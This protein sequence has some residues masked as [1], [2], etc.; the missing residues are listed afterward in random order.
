MINS[1][2]GRTERWLCRMWRVTNKKLQLHIRWVRERAGDV[3][4]SI[5]DELADLGTRVEAQH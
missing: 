4:N 5:A 1:W 3:G 2:R